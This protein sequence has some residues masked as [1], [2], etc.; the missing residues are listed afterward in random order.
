MSGKILIEPIYSSSDQI[1]EKDCFS[2]IYRLSH[3]PTN[4]L[5]NGALRKYQE[6]EELNCLINLLNIRIQHFCIYDQTLNI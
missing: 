3:R 2:N 4:C 6:L 5:L 1:K